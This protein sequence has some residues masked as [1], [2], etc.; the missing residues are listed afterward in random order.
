MKQDAPF[1]HRAAAAIT[2]SIIFDVLDYLAAPLFDAPIIG[3]VLDV[4]VTTLLYS[5]TKSKA[6][7]AV[8]ITKLTPGIGIFVPT[9]TLSTLLW[10][11]RELKKE[12]K[13][14]LKKMVYCS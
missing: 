2:I 1:A 10:I 6:S 14:K 4:I 7:T 5:I 8:N 11:S 3:D 13:I 9:Y 12:N